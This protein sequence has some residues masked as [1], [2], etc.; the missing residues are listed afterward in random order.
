MATAGGRRDEQVTDHRYVTVNGK[1]AAWL[2][3]E[4]E[5]DKP[6]G[7]LIPWVTP[8]KWPEWGGE[9][10][11]EMKPVGSRQESTSGDEWQAKYL[12]VVNLAG[13]ELN[14]VLR[15]DFGRT[16]QWAAL[17]YDLD[18]S[19]DD[20]LQ[21]DRGFLLAVEAPNE[22]RQ[23]KALKVV[24]FTDPIETFAVDAVGGEWT[25]W[26]RQAI[27]LAAEKGDRDPSVG[28]H[29]SAA[30]VTL[31][32][33]SDYYQDWSHQWTEC[34]GDMAEFY[35]G[36]A[37]DVGSRLWSG[38]YNQGDA[39]QDSGRLF[40]RMAR[41]WSRLCRAGS[42]MAADFAEADVPST[43]GGSSTTEY[44]DVL[45][46][47]PTRPAQVSVGNLVKV[48][49]EDTTLKPAHVEV[50]PDTVATSTPDPATIRLQVNPRLGP[51]GLYAGD[52]TVTPGATHPAFV[53]I[54][55]A[56]PVA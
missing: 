30:R 18:H 14:T 7:E 38:Q 13:Q 32:S 34:V 2:F 29:G 17:T 26:I 15:C 49:L 11:K 12:E 45:V 54:S 55:K 28:H 1:R 51:S 47:A 36:Y 41:D 21:V 39:T 56:R 33:A 9:I 16:K 31:N 27:K 40:L 25:H 44:T 8:E 35:R 53:Y 24:G 3:S 4:F 19:V 5:T 42:Q 43:G 20:R 23:V 6:L 48:G 10:F 52:V 50:G 37:T 22:R 46:S